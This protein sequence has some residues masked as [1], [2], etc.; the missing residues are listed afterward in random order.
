MGR[1][2]RI[3]RSSEAIIRRRRR[4]RRRRRAAETR[5]RETSREEVLQLGLRLKLQLTDRAAD[6]AAVHAGGT[7]LAAGSAGSKPHLRSSTAPL[8]T[9]ICI[10]SLRW[11]YDTQQS[12]SSTNR[13]TRRR[14]DPIGASPPALHCPLHYDR[15][16]ASRGL[17]RHAKKRLI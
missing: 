2:S 3:R 1:R 11:R 13:G 8:D 17:H 4:D 6:A 12:T 9:G 16:H 15:V 10:L 5:L 7:D 14:I